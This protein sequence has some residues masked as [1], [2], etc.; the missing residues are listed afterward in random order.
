MARAWDPAPDLVLYRGRIYTVDPDDAVVEALAVKDDRI[1]AVGSSDAV[2]RR[3]LRASPGDAP[4]G[5]R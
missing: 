3:S 5:S 1:V 2:R 4:A